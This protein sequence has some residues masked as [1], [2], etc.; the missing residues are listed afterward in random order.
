[1]FRLIGFVLAAWPLIKWMRGRKEEKR[2]RA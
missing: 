2:A 1:M